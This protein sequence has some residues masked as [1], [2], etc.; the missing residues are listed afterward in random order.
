MADDA[1]AD[2]ESARDDNVRAE[3]RAARGR[4]LF[5]QCNANKQYRIAAK[6]ILREFGW[7][8]FCMRAPTSGD[9]WQH[10]TVCYVYEL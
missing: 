4:K 7:P 10:N 5:C 9:P 3:G 1:D 8:M 6:T 2:V